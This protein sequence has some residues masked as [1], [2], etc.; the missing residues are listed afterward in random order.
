MRN[1]DLDH[2]HFSA[3][4][5]ARVARPYFT[6]SSLILSPGFAAGMTQMG[7]ATSAALSSDL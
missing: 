5:F 1:A 6:G 7:V 2:D 3:F 4:H